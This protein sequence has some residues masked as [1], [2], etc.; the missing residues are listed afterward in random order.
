MLQVVGLNVA[1][2]IATCGLQVCRKL[3]RI[4]I[5]YSDIKEVRSI[6][7]ELDT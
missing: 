4:A 2:H 5:V 3:D 1:F 7:A 6:Q